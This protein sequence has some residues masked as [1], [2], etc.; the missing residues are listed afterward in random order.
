MNFNVEFDA[1]VLPIFIL[2]KNQRQ[3]ILLI[4]KPG[5]RFPNRISSFS[6]SEVG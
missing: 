2:Y 4:V 1:C 3:D 6:I 5:F